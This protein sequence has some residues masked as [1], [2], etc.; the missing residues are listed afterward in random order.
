M[1]ASP[2]PAEPIRECA[3][4]NLTPFRQTPARGPRV[5]GSTALS[6][7]D[8]L[9]AFGSET[10]PSEAPPS[11][12][13]AAKSKFTLRIPVGAVL[14]L[15]I[16]GLVGLATGA[17]GM[18]LYQRSLGGWGTGLVR[19]ETSGAAPADVT[20]AGRVVGKTPVSLALAPGSYAVQL[21]GAGGRRDF[22]VDV[23]RGTSIVRHV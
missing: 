3:F 10:E 17:A 18:W 23:A 14:P 1:A 13:A 16:V 11:A 7:G 4:M 6:D 21:A 5:E 9:D 20:V 22:T 12:P 8:S 2:S 19:I 15:A